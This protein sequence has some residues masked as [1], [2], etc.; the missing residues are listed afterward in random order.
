[1]RTR[2]IA[3]RRGRA[4]ELALVLA[5]VFS[6]FQKA[7]SDDEAA[8]ALEALE[9]DATFASIRCPECRWRP[10]DA[11]AWYCGDNAFPERFFGGCG[12]S[13]NTFATKGLCPGCS[14]RWRWTACLRCGIWSLHDEWYAEESSNP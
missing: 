7:Q 3:P 10:S 6:L 14:H 2:L 4:S 1:M 11:D 5:G 13:W 9:D 8:R 12:T